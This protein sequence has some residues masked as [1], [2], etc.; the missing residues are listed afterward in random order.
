[1]KKLMCFVLF[2][3]M[4]RICLAQAEV[5]VPAPTPITTPVVAP[6]NQLV[7]LIFTNDKPENIIVLDS[8]GKWMPDVRSVTINM[9]LG[10]PPACECVMW[11]GPFKPSSPIRATYTLKQAKSVTQEEFQKMIDDLQLNP[12]ALKK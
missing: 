4:P 12:N 5:P 3:V 8:T 1:M 11:S 10:Q 7:F 9:S 2:A 6:Q